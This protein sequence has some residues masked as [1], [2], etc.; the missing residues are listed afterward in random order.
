MSLLELWLPVLLSAVAV[1]FASFVAWTIL[2]HHKKDW[3]RLPDHDAFA[4][5]VK[6]LEIPPG[7]YLY[8]NVATNAEMKEEAYQQRFKD[9]PWG[10]LSI[11]PAA[12]NMCQRWYL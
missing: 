8:P 9:G 7:Q 3:R 10:T 12:P 1:F 5:A 4:D 11:W 2:P 6:K